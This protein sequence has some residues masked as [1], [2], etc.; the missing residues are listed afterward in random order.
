[1]QYFPDTFIGHIGFPSRISYVEETRELTVPEKIL[2]GG[3]GENDFSIYFVIQ[4][5]FKISN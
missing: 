4:S 3:F 1:M 5:T 2:T